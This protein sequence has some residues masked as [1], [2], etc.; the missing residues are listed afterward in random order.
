MKN[1]KHKENVFLNNKHVLLYNNHQTLFD[2]K[3]FDYMQHHFCG[4]VFSD[5]YKF[6][7]HERQPN[8]ILYLCGNVK[9]IIH[10]VNLINIK[11]INIIKEFST[12]FECDHNLINLGE[13]PINI[14]NVGVYLRNFFDSEKNYYDLITK[15]HDFQ[16]LTISNLPNTAYR[17][18]IY[19]TKVEQDQENNIKFKLLRCSTDLNGPTDN[20]ISTDNEII[21]KVNNISQ[22]FFKEK[23][24]LNHVLAQTYHNTINTTT[25]KQKKARIAQHSDKTKD[26]PKNALMAFCTFYK[27]LKSKKKS[28]NNSFD[29]CYKNISVLT[30]LRFK[31]KKEVTD[32]TL[33]KNFDIILYPNSV[34]LMSLK[35]NR[36]Y[37]HEI[38]PS[39]LPIDKI[40]TRLGY[41]IRCSN[42]DAIYKNDQTYIYKYGKYF[43]LEPS[44]KKNI[45]ELKKLYLKENMTAKI[46]DY[47]DKFY[48]SLNRGDYMKPN[49]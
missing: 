40:P 41:V 33:N 17:K 6:N 1:N 7:N 39:I 22:Y 49:L 34:F 35:S 2:N 21:D 26:M 31:L 15:N 10:Q 23:V 20:F 42:T 45:K 19:L 36:L 16:S 5:V 27:D 9:E 48:F 24:E 4:I 43:K 12:N 29:Y 46:I 30:R 44:T 18:G 11:I 25:H 14:F 37:T 3:D 47:E 8:T 13:V 38:A 32:N 28:K